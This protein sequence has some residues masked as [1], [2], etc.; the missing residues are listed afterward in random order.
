MTR[1]KTPPPTA[2]PILPAPGSSP[3]IRPQTELADPGAAASSDASARV[4]TP[5]D[6]A[7]EIAAPILAAS[8]LAAPILPVSFYARDAVT[9]ARALLGKLLVRETSRSVLAARI[10]EVEAY[11][12]PFDQ[13]AH[14]ANGR[15]TPR[16]E[17]MWGPPGRAYVYFVYGMHWCLNAVTAA[18]GHPEA[19][20][21]RGLEPLLGHAT[22]RRR[23]RAQLRPSHRSKPP[24][25]DSRLLDGPAKICSA[26]ALDRRFDGHDLR[27]PP[28]TIRDA[29][30]LP[31]SEVSPTPRIGVAYAGEHAQL[32]WR[33]VVRGP[34]HQPRLP[35][36]F[37]DSPDGP[38]SI[39]RS[40]IRMASSPS[41]PD[42]RRNR[43]RP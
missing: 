1:A 5:N 4:A 23:R 37:R 43:Q 17:T 42:R 35:R 39:G 10:V 15:R 31:D 38:D 27:A 25:R 8:I 33:F 6:A 22:F 28:L 12:G 24:I 30:D 40:P 11:R 18:E 34:A 9:V 16:N 7:A 13:A 20:L 32:L 21:L 3:P 36:S 41:V 26:F 14:S 29:Y 19:V 2:V